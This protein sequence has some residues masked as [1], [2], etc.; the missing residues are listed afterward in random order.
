MSGYGVPLMRYVAHYQ[1]VIEVYAAGREAAFVG[2][3]AGMYHAYVE[4]G[5]FPVACLQLEAVQF[6]FG[7]GEGIAERT[8][9][10]EGGCFGQGGED[11]G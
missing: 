3:I 11:G 4:R 8:T 1:G 6:A 7:V 2:E 10:E 9:L 5:D